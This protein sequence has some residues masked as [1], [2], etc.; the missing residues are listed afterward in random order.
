MRQGITPCKGRS[1]NLSHKLREK[2]CDG[3]VLLSL[4]PNPADEKPKDVR[5]KCRMCGTK[6]SFYCTGCKNFLCYGPSQSFAQV[7][8]D[9]IKLLME[10]DTDGILGARQ[11]PKMLVIQEFDPTDEEWQPALFASNCCYL[12]HH[13]EAFD[14]L[15]EMKRMARYE[16]EGDNNE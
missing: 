15:W 9:R 4:I 16:T 11:P 6:T 5:S 3:R 12:V 10:K 8:T 1:I 7:K 13:K 2:H 14:K